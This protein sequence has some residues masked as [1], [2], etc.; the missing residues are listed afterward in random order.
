[1]SELQDKVK[2]LKGDNAL[3]E[4]DYEDLHV[5]LSQSKVFRYLH[6]LELPWV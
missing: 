6:H 3:L 1:M 2:K 4:D 5:Q